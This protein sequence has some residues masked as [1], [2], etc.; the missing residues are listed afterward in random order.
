MI[1]VKNKMTMLPPLTDRRY[2][3][4]MS[5]EKKVLLGCGIGCGTITILVLIAIAFGVWWLFSPEDQVPTNRILNTGSS[6]AFRLEDISRNQDVMRLISDIS[7][8]TQ[9]IKQNNMPNR[10]LSG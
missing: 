6:A 2:S 8:E 7:R 10:A 4:K 3:N 9:R 5:A 1:E